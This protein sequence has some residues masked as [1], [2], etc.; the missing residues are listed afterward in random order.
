MDD[1]TWMGKHRFLSPNGYKTVFYFLNYFY[2]LNIFY[3]LYLLCL[4]Y[5]C[6]FEDCLNVLYNQMC[7]T[8]YLTNCNVFQL[9]KF[10][11]IYYNCKRVICKMLIY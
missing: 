11:F 8:V 6:S 1:I 3:D 10:G 4:S 5:L 9:N 2:Y 7:H